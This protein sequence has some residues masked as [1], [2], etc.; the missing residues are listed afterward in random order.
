MLAG[1]AASLSLAAA[2]LFVVLHALLHELLFVFVSVRHLLGRLR[3]GRPTRAAAAAAAPASTQQG[4]VVPTSVQWLRQ[5]VLLP[6]ERHDFCRWCMTLTQNLMVAPVA[7]YSLWVETVRVDSDAFGSLRPSHATLLW[8]F[9]EEP[10]LQ[11]L[12]TTPW[13]LVCFAVLLGHTLYD[14]AFW[15]FHW[16]RFA[17]HPD[18][19]LVCHH[20]VTLAV[21]VGTLLVDQGAFYV[22]LQMLHEGSSPLIAMR[23]LLHLVGRGPYEPVCVWNLTALLCTFV[24]C[25]DAVNVL[26]LLHMTYNWRLWTSGVMRPAFATLLVV[27]AVFMTLL[28][29]VWTYIF[30]HRWRRVWHHWQTTQQQRQKDG[31]VSVPVSADA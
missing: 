13:R 19:S 28:S 8:F 7:L 29:G 12:T 17:Q 2:A 21:L 22:C 4:A 31:P 11:S 14:F 23:V 10:V 26:T 5:R 30:Y 25:H 6:S 15:L 16:L 1:A 9:R 20:A 27:C 18:W 3:L 24:W